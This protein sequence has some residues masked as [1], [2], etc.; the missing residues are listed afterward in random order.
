MGVKGPKNGKITDTCIPE[1]T[2]SN[3][4]V[5]LILSMYS[6]EDIET[7]FFHYTTNGFE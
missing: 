2:D 3:R 5:K 6:L 7:Y 1:H 4:Y